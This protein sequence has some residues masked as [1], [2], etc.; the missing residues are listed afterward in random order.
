VIT[1]VEQPHL[2]SALEQANRRREREGV[3][4]VGWLA[5]GI[6]LFFWSALILVVVIARAIAEEDN[7]QPGGAPPAAPGIPCTPEMFALAAAVGCMLAVRGWQF[8]SEPVFHARLAAVL[9]GLLLVLSLILVY[10]VRWL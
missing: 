9:N 10:V 4:V 3:R 2:L 5:L 6:G 7:N 1:P 8:E